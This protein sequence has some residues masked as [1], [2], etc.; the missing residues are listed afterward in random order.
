MKYFELY[1][2]IPSKKNSKE[3]SIIK[4]KTAKGYKSVPSVRCSDR[5]KLW[6]D[7]AVIELRKQA[8]GFHT[9]KCKIVMRFFYGDNIRRDTDNGVSSIFDTLVDA[10]ILEDDSWKNVPEHHVSGGYDKALPRCEIEIYDLD[11]RIEL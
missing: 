9:E 10:G 5:Y 8:R 6:H 4:K 2:N 7:V 3:I 11:E 1:G